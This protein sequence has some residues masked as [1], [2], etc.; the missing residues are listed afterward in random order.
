MKITRQFNYERRFIIAF[1]VIGVL[2]SVALVLVGYWYGRQSGNEAT[3]SAI[4]QANVRTTSSTNAS[5]KLAQKEGE[6]TNFRSGLV[7]NSGFTPG[8]PDFAIDYP[9]GCTGEV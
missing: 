1:L 8:Y 7:M 4:H 6:T 3:T 5:Y 9:Y 2:A